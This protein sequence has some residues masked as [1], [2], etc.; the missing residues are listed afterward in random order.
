MSILDQNS[1]NLA[2][3]LYLEQKTIPQISKLVGICQNSLRNYL[4]KCGIYDTNRDTKTAK[5]GCTNSDFFHTIDSEEKAYWLGFI[6]ADGCIITSPSNIHT[7][8]LSVTLSKKDEQHLRKLSNIF[9]K[10]LKYVSHP[11]S[12]SENNNINYFARLDINSK[13]MY[14]D[15][16]NNGMEERKT[17]SN[18]IK[19]FDRVS[20]NLK[21]HFI[22]GI[23]D[24]DGS[25]SYWGNDKR[26][27]KFNIC[28]PQT[29]LENVQTI[30]INDIQQLPKTKFSFSSNIYYLQYGGINEIKDIYLWMYKDAHIYLERKKDKFEEIINAHTNA[31]N[32]IAMI[33]NY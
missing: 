30:M 18:S 27:C 24:G 1:L 13:E 3:S 29:I 4:T 5:F 12:L 28:G 22:R 26:N 2:K 15:L 33:T 14:K 31:H 25:I 9:N 11:C 10:P 32:A 8:R 6:Y 19:I 16:T 20:A 21:H 23:F 17:G 7:F